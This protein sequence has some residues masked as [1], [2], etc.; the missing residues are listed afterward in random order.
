MINLKKIKITAKTKKYLLSSIAGIFVLFLLMDALFP[1]SAKIE[2]SQIITDSKGRILH[3]FL[4]SDDKWRMKTELEEITPELQEAIVF[5]E[6]KWFYYHLG[7]N[8]LAI[9]RAAFNNIVKGKR[10]SGAST[11]TMQV[12]RLLQPKE[13]SYFNKILE[14]WHALQLEW[15]FSKKEILQLY[16]NL[17]P[18]GGNIE[19]VK[20]AAVLYFDKA[21]NHLSIAEITTLAIIPNR[22]TSLL[23]G[24][25][26]AKV[27]EAR[28][29]WL[30]RFQASKVFDQQ[31][32]EDALTEPLNA[33]RLESPRIAPHFAYRMKYEHPDEPIIKTTLQYNQQLKVEKL[34]SNYIQR[35][36][37]QRI[38]NAAVMVL[39]NNTNQVEAYVGSSDFFNSEAS[40]QVD[41]V[42][43]NRSPGSTLKPFL[44][45]LAFDKGLLTPKYKISD[46]PTN[47]T[48]Y[49]PVN[50]SGEYEGM[51]TIEYAL[52][53]SLNV[54]A[55]KVLDE[56]GVD[57][58]LGKLSD[59]GF[60]YIKRNQNNLGLSVALGGCGVR[61]DELTALYAAFAND[62]NIREP[63][64]I[65][66]DTARLNVPIMSESAAFI[67]TEILT[68]LTRPDLPKN[69]ESSINLPKIA[70]K[71]GT[72][73][74]RKDAWSVGYNGNY[75]IGVWC[76]N[77]SGEGVPDL[78]GATVA[79]PLLFNIFNSIDYQSQK[80]WFQPPK[81]LDYR[82]VC[83]ESGLPPNEHCSEQVMDTYLPLVSNTLKCKHYQEVR[84]NPDESHAFCTSCTPS[85]GFK[86]KIFPNYPPEIIAYYEKENIPYDKIPPHNPKCERVF[87]DLAAAPK[88][89]SPV[90]GLEYLI[91]PQDNTQLMLSCN[92]P[93]STEK[94]YW[95]INDRFFQSATSTENL[96]FEPKEGKN[97]ITCVDDKGRKEYIW[98]EVKSL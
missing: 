2:H 45:G 38:T 6:D 54:P 59:A 46:V 77:F 71:T 31:A 35:I 13:R 8:P 34:A 28:N 69:I 66:G 4:T 55:V 30:Q 73:Y 88:I 85:L 43:S 44:Y 65:L 62:G 67:V 15:H 57:Y 40:G 18:Y 76:G 94:V 89:T 80:T 56:M 39:N 19:G 14:M 95:Y 75:T 7:V 41:G 78:T 93:S 23:L 16:L 37:H 5:K 64:Y 87:S 61:L 29:E 33:Q 90:D 21:P 1:F 51:V 63:Q 82:W 53:N 68:Q 58:F 97:K 10:T 25:N 32:I 11:I 92:A 24:K 91:D 86:K 96:F 84:L 36:Y 47:F 17:V 83:S 49:S 20:S 27:K 48:G 74:G 50:Y 72:S 79:T 26:N 9:G 22:P 52:A 60:S 81:D 42:R 12:A 98:V 70:W 3:A